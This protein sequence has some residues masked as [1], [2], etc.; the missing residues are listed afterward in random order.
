MGDGA[1][2]VVSWV[3]DNC[4]VTSVRQALVLPHTNELTGL[5]RRVNVLQMFSA[6][7]IFEIVRVEKC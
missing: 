1:L 2:F 5:R 4:I 6:E 3:G 7:F